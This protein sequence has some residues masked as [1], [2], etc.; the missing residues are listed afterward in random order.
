MNSG[1]R[2]FCSNAFKRVGGSGISFPIPHF[3][4]PIVQIENSPL[5]T[6][7]STKFS[8]TTNSS[9]PKAMAQLMG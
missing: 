1:Y 7:F 6:L 5:V 3:P 4:F 8:A 2:T 9:I